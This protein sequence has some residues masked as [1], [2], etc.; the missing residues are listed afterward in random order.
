MLTHLLGL[1]QFGQGVSEK[2]SEP[3]LGWLK[4][5][6]EINKGMRNEIQLAPKWN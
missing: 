6:Y 2:P 4:G 5:S 3:C 1:E